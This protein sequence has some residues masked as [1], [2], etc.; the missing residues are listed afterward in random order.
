MGYIQDNLMPNE[1]VLFTANVHP[2]VFL[3]S[4]FSFV[5]SVGFVVYALMTGGKG[6]MTSG[7]LAGFLLL[8]AIWFFLSSIFL[9]V[10][11]LIILLTTEF[12]VTNKRVIAN[13]QSSHS[14]ERFQT[15]EMKRRLRHLRR[16][17]TLYACP[18]VMAHRKATS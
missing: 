3:P 6:D 8:T 16:Y 11:A 1:K 10:Q 2:A 13:L 18:R 12:A 4:V 17:R 14:K 5:V 9:G 7:L 15:V